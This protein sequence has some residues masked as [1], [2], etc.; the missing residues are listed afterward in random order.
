MTRPDEDSCSSKPSASSGLLHPRQP[1]RQD[2]LGDLRKRPPRPILTVQGGYDSPD[3]AAITPRAV[4]DVLVKTCLERER[5]GHRLTRCGRVTTPV[6]RQAG[7]QHQA[8][9]GLRAGRPIHRHRARR[10]VDINAELAAGAGDGKDDGLATLVP[11]RIGHKL[12]GE[13]DRGSWVDRGIPGVDSR[14]S[15]VA[16][17]PGPGAAAV[18]HRPGNGWAMGVSVD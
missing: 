9:P 6:T 3:P 1:D 7:D 8:T 18:E 2:R 16:G 15:A 13:Q 4:A 12:A 14:V 10:V 5:E 17:G 11:D